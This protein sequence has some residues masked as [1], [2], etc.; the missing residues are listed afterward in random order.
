M[1]R[2]KSRRGRRSFGRKRRK[3]TRGWRRRTI[4]AMRKG[5]IRTG[6]VLKPELKWYDQSDTGNITAT[7]ASIMNAGVSLNS[8][9]QGAGA[10]ERIG[11][12]AIMRA[13]QFRMTL[14]CPG[15]EEASE[16]INGNQVRIILAVDHQCNGA[17]PAGS[18]ILQSA[19]EINSFRNLQVTSRFTVLMDKTVSL[20]PGACYNGSAGSHLAIQRSVTCN[21]YKKLSMLSQYDNANPDV[22]TSQTN[23]SLVLFAFADTITPQIT[24]DWQTRVRYVG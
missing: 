23:N 2:Y 24:Y 21:F 16:T 19:T 9:G 4:K 13:I 15:A 5:N 22:I 11:D 1:A 12:K 18:D 20:N 7:F 17:L 14:K 3:P 10:S 6:G 8:I